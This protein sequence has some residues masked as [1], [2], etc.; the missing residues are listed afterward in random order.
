M[1]TRKI[2]NTNLA[3]T[4]KAPLS[5]AVTANGMVYVSGTTPFDLE[6][7]MASDFPGQMHQV[8][9]NM[10]AILEESGSSLDQIVKVNVFLTDIRDFAA[11]NEIYASYFEE[12]N[13][14]ART[15]VEAP[16][17]VPNMLLEIECIATVSDAS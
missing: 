9:Q 5:Q 7:K 13:Y 12:G 16:M 11:M 10:K 15:T 14:P 1:S 4:A 3:P 8:M 2:I 6:R 17:A